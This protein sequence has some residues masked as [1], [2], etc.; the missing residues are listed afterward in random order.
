MS[1]DGFMAARTTISSPFET[2][3]SIPPA[4]FVADSSRSLRISSC[5]AEPR[6]DASSNP[7]PISI[8]T[9]LRPHQG[10]VRGVVLRRVRAQTRQQTPRARTSTTP[11]TGLSARASSRTAAEI[12][13]EYATF[14]GRSRRAAP[15]PP[16]TA[17]SLRCGARSPAPVRRG[18]QYRSYLSTPARSACPG[19]GRVTSLRLPLQKDRPFVCCHGLIPQDP[20]LCLYD[21]RQRRSHAPPRRRPASTST[22]SCSIC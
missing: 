19:R 11:P 9:G 13:G 15:S 3:P 17:R 5:A 7:S 1:V 8:F 22:S 18:R 20:V 21:Q 6:I 2:P 14:D 16:A 10:C 4:R 12:G